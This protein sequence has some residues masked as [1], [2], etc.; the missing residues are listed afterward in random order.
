MA[1][2]SMRGRAP[3]KPP[4]NRV[5]GITVTMPE[6]FWDQIDRLA[7]EQHIGRS[8]VVRNA[9]REHLNLTLEPAEQQE[10]TNATA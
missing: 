6:T 3:I 4:A 5:R 8:E 1:K 2:Y 7:Y 10:A 9:L